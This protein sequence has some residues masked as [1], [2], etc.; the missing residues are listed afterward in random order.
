[1][2]ALTRKGIKRS[3]DLWYQPRKDEEE[4]AFL[5]AVDIL[6]EFPISD[7]FTL[8]NR[9]PFVHGIERKTSTVRK[10][11]EDDLIEKVR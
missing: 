1:V 6:D 8:A 2:L 10:W 11:I 7:T 5:A 4:M 9:L 3:E